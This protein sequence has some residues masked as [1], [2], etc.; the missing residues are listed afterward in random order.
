MEGRLAYISQEE[1]H[2][3]RTVGPAGPYRFMRRPS[4][5]KSLATLQ[6]RERERECQTS[7]RLKVTKVTRSE[8]QQSS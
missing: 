3:L 1:R 4:L 8:F 7:R 2:P 6:E 5:A